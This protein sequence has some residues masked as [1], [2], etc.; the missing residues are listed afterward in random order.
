MKGLILIRLRRTHP[1]GDYNTHDIPCQNIFGFINTLYR[2]SMDPSVILS[3]LSLQIS[4]HKH[5]TYTL[6]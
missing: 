5:Q 6:L 2:S 4:G 3:Y 1:N